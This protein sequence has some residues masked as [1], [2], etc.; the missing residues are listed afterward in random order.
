MNDERAGACEAGGE[1]RTESARRAGDERDA[2]GQVEGILRWHGAEGE[3]W[4]PM[5]ACDAS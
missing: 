4:S 2:S 5:G 3:R 1:R